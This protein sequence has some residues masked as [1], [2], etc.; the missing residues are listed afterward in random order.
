MVLDIQFHLGQ[1]QA[2]HVI[3]YLVHAVKFGISK[4]QELVE[5]KL[6]LR[7]EE[8]VDGAICYNNIFEEI[9]DNLRARVSKTETE[10]HS[11]IDTIVDKILAFCNSI[12]MHGPK[13]KKHNA[14]Q[15]DDAFCRF[16]ELL[17]GGGCRFQKEA[18]FKVSILIALTL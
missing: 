8:N 5:A 4:T 13:E 14:V 16:R 11:S 10:T 6:R 18:N 1:V 7:T 3:Q 15:I 12:G 17:V 9:G 2:G